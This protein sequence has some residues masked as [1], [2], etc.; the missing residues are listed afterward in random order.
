MK[1]LF[2]KIEVYL[3]KCIICH[4]YLNRNSVKIFYIA[5]RLFWE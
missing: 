3:R 5:D 1:Y 4:Q 2:V